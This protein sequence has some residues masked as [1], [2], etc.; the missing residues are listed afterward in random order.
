MCQGRL[1]IRLRLANKI[2]IK[3]ETG[4]ELLHQSWCEIGRQGRPQFDPL[5]TQSQQGKVNG[6]SLLFKPGEHDRQRQVIDPT[7]ERLGQGTR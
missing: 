2:Q 1:Q 5:D 4:L 3:I 7:I 6:G